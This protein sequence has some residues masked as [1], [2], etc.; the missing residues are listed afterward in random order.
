[1]NENRTPA[2]RSVRPL[3]PTGTERVKNAPTRELLED[4]LHDARTLIEKEIALAKA[5]LRSD[6]KSEIAMAR[7]LGIAAVLG[8][9][10]LS[11]VFVA[12]ALALGLVLAPWLAALIV[13]V[14]LLLLGAAFGAAGWARRNRAPLEVTR[15]T[16]KE[17]WQWAKNHVA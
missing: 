12:G 15:Q 8:L 11:V 10:G 5:E 4:S 16:L 3:D 9:C 6:L 2:N 13:G 1:M 14:A 17:D 7:D